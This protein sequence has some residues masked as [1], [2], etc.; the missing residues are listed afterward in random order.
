M[1]NKRKIAGLLVV[2]GVVANNIVYLQ[3]LWFGQSVISLDSWRA[4]LGILICLAVVGAGLVRL[5][6]AD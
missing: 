3:D 5:L 6:Q 1:S 2:V 4:Y